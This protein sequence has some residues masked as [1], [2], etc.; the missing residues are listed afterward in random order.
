MDPKEAEHLRNAFPVLHF[1]VGVMVGGDHTYVPESQNFDL[2]LSYTAT[3]EEIENDLMEAIGDCS[4]LL[5]RKMK[6]RAPDV[7]FG[8]DRVREAWALEE[9]E[10]GEPI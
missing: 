2:A 6:E 7:I 1:N 9:E 5:M 8:A 10:D 4:E 3:K